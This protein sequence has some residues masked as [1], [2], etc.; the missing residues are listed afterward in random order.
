VDKL[1]LNTDANTA[2]PVERGSHTYRW[3]HEEDA[4]RAVDAGSSSVPKL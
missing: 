2:W 1:V 3:Q 4:P